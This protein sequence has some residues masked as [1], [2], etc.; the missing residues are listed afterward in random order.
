PALRC[1][2]FALVQPTQGIGARLNVAWHRH[3]SHNYSAGCAAHGGGIWLAGGV[4]AFRL[5]GAADFTAG[6]GRFVEE[7]SEGN[8]V[9][10]RWR[11]GGTAI[12]FGPNRP[13]RIELARD[14]A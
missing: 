14:L 13:G 2:H 4:C 1:G 6:C 10:P 9:V 8:G 12:T 11:F 5:R 3:W 7:R